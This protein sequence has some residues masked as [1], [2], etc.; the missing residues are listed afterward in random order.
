MTLLATCAIEKFWALSYISKYLFWAKVTFYKIHIIAMIKLYILI[1][2]KSAQ[3]LGQ[4]KKFQHLKAEDIQ[5]CKPFPA[6]L[7][8]LVPD[9]FPILSFSYKITNLLELLF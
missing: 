6:Q 5:P 3:I 4:L 1:L 8:H 9:S 2:H 7:K